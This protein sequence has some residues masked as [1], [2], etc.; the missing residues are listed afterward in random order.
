VGPTFGLPCLMTRSM[1]ARLS[2]TT[3]GKVT[4]IEVLAHQGS[5]LSAVRWARDHALANCSILAS[6]EENGL[7]AA[8]DHQCPRQN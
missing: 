4:L 7:G 5:G 3:L 6:F 1:K 8:L 2:D